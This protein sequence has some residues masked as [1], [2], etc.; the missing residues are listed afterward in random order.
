MSDGYKSRKFWISIYLS[1][2]AHLF[3]AAGI[4]D[5]AVWLAAQGAALSVFTVGNVTEKWAPK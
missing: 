3:V 2:T 4:I 1:S 5:S